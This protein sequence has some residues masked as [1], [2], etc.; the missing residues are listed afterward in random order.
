[1]SEV[2]NEGN[3]KQKDE[4]INANYSIHKIVYIR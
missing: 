4:N 3:K 2:A 1:M